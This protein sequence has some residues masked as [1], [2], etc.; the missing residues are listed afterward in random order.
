MRCE[1]HPLGA[2]QTSKELSLLWRDHRDPVHRVD[3]IRTDHVDEYVRRLMIRGDRPRPARPPPR[4]PRQKLGGMLPIEIVQ[5]MESRQSAVGES[6]S[7]LG[8]QVE[9]A[10]PGHAVLRK[11]RADPLSEHCTSSDGFFLTF[12]HQI[13]LHVKAAR[14][15]MADELIDSRVT[16]P[17][18]IT[19]SYDLNAH[20]LRTGS[21]DNLG[22]RDAQRT[23]MRC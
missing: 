10:V 14:I 5:E 13:L 11:A 17:V 3:D 9:R 16:S 15:E 4:P 1:T 23:L 8:L 12:R 22:R 6:R 20:R 7:H 2:D 21:P 18:R 19:R